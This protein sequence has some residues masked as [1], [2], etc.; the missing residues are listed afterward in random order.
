VIGPDASYEPLF[1]YQIE[2]DDTLLMA[3]SAC[4]VGGK[5]PSDATI[6]RNVVD[7][8][9]NVVHTLDALPLELQKKGKVRCYEELDSLPGGTLQPGD[10]MLHIVAKDDG[11]T[12]LVNE[13]VPLLVQ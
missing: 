3:W 6:E 11:G 5:L 2:P 10:Y 7:D 8:D 1:V 12:E 4:I 9:G 13:S